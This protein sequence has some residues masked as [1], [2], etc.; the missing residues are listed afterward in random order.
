VPTKIITETPRNP[1]NPGAYN[2]ESTPERAGGSRFAMRQTFEGM[3][4]SSPAAGIAAAYAELANA[5]L[6]QTPESRPEPKAIRL[7]AVVKTADGYQLVPRGVFR[8]VPE[9]V[10]EADQRFR[11]QTKE[12]GELLD[13]VFLGQT[14]ARDDNV[15]AALL[16]LCEQEQPDGLTV[17]SLSDSTAILLAAKAGIRVRPDELPVIG[18]E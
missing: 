1:R 11:G 8:S 14:N 10:L 16:D 7:Q 12:G 13:A 6:E 3:K 18:R 2:L 15:W 9:L 17:R 5:R 4:V